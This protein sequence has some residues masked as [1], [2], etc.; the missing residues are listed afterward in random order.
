MNRNLRNTLLK[1]G[2]PGYVYNGEKGLAKWRS[3][4]KQLKAGAG[5]IYNLNFIGDSIT[6]GALSD[7]EPQNW[8]TKGFVGNVRNKLTAMF[9]DT[10]TGFIPVYH[11]YGHPFW[12]LNGSWALDEE[13]DIGVSKICALCPSATSTMTFTFTGTALK[14]LYGIGSIVG[15]FDWKIDAG[16]NTR[17]NSYGASLAVGE[18]NITGLS[19]ASHTLTITKVADDNYVAIF[20]AYPV[21]GTRGI[22]CN[23]MG[24]FGKFAADFV[25]YTGGEALVQGLEIDYWTPTLTVISLILNDAEAGTSVATYKSQLQTLIT[26]AKAYGDVLLFNNAFTIAPPLAYSSAIPYSNALKDLAVA[27]NICYVDLCAAV[28]GPAM[29]LA[30][31]FVDVDGLH[32]NASG[33]AA[34]ADIFLKKA[35][36]A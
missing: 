35:L 23:Q 30:K 22:R 6:E 8:I 31:G 32:W 10:G 33:H 17:V 3:A 14:V 25:D 27:N 4:L 26:S 19:D 13:W 2:Y 20:G 11:P 7:A 16:S 29:A 28:G 12:T 15:Q 21:K 5:T 18:I 9:G 34:V 1:P 36:L 24:S